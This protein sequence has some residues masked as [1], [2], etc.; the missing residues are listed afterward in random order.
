LGP[1]ALQATQYPRR[2]AA[3]CRFRRHVALPAIPLRTPSFLC[4]TARVHEKTPPEL[5]VAARRPPLPPLAPLAAALRGAPRL[6]TRA[7]L[8]SA[9]RAVAPAQ[10]HT[11][12]AAAPRD[13]HAAP[14]AS[15]AATCRRG[16]QHASDTVALG[17]LATPCCALATRLSPAGLRCRLLR[18]GSVVAW[19]PRLSWLLCHWHRRC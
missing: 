13:V 3:N 12:A 19:T 9:A 4:A 7:V 10:R 11:H 2:Y 16:S 1:W 18:T 5:H 15:A 14:P 8:G 6:R 17:S